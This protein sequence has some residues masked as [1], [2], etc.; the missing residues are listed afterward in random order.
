LVSQFLTQHGAENHQASETVELI[1]PGDIPPLHLENCGA[2]V[3]VAVIVTSSGAEGKL[4]KFAM[5]QVTPPAV[6][7][8]NEALKLVAEPTVV[9]PPQIVA[10]NMPNLGDPM[11]SIPAPHRMELGLRW[12][13]I[14][15][16]WRRGSGEGQSVG[17]GSGNCGGVF[18]VGGGVSAPRTFLIPNL[19]I[20]RKHAKRNTKVSAF[21]GWL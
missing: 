10:S 14:R 15:F 19:N 6:V 4:P 8:R 18:R 12:H 2:A 13:W 20:P 9:V 5:E 3:A 17:P 1:A 16:W 11:S 21:Y 7:V